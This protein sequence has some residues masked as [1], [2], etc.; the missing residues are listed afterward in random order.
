M[1]QE[2]L[3]CKLITLCLSLKVDNLTF[4]AFLTGVWTQLTITAVLHCIHFTFTVI[5]ICMV[6]SRCNLTTLSL[7]VAAS[8]NL[9]ASV[10]HLQLTQQL[11]SFSFHIIHSGQKINY[12]RQQLWLAQCKEPSHLILIYS[13]A[14]ALSRHAWLTAET[15]YLSV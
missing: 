14:E 15:S 1:I 12:S 13:Y 3:I 6:I 9:K 7:D 5:T 10:T 8:C 11:N 4:L 2:T